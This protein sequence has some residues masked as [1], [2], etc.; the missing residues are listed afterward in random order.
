MNQKD[1]QM[2]EMYS[3]AAEDASPMLVYDCKTNSGKNP[4][5]EDLQQL[6]ELPADYRMLRKAVSTLIDSRADVSM[7]NRFSFSAYSLASSV[8]TSLSLSRPALLQCTFCSVHSSLLDIWNQT[9]D[10]VSERLINNRKK[11]R[12]TKIKF[13]V[14]GGIGLKWEDYR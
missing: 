5:Y 3:H 14:K 1:H 9:K 8:D 2:M 10:A 7:K 12:K 11:C 4:F 13:L 6:Y